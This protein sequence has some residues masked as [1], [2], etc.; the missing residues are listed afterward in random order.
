M[1]SCDRLH[2]AI[3]AIDILIKTQKEENTKEAYERVSRA[4][5]H[6][7]AEYLNQPLSLSPI[8][9]ELIEEMEKTHQNTIRATMKRQGI[10]LDKLDIYFWLGNG[11]RKIAW[12]AIIRIF[13]EFKGVI[14]TSKS[15]PIVQEYAASF[16]NEILSQWDIWKKEFLDYTQQLG[17]RTFKG[18]MLASQ[19]LWYECNQITGSGY[20][21][22][23]IQKL[24]EWFNEPPQCESQK[25]LNSQIDN[26]SQE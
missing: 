23:V 9:L 25:I 2:G 12:N 1:A 6:F 3:N 4:L 11:S 7:L 22:E 21:N 24:K 8:Y 5:N 20:R 18:R 16:L 13:Y 19:W 26:D 17:E 10:Y 14:K 15:D